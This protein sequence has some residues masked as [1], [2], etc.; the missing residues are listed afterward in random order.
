MIKIILCFG[1]MKAWFIIKNGEIIGNPTGYET[2]KKARKGAE[3]TKDY[4][5][6]TKKY[7]LLINKEKLIDELKNSK[8]YQKGCS[9]DWY[10][11]IH[12]K[13]YKNVWKTFVKENYQFEQKEFDIVFKN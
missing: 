2:E 3:K 9:K 5:K 8:V 7:P 11:L 13:W 12:E 1:N 6:L 10:V 4:K